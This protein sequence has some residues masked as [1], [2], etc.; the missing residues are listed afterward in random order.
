MRRE[1]IVGV[2]VVTA[3][4]RGPVALGTLANFSRGGAQVD[5]LAPLELGRQ[6]RVSLHVGAANS[7]LSF[8]GQVRWR[9]G[10]QGGFAHGIAFSSVEPALE[11]R[12]KELLQPQA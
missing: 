8:Q 9:L 2:K 3:P 11:A 6:V 5:L 1:I 12:L 4:D 7:P 10:V